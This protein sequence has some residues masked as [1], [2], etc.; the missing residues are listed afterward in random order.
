MPKKLLTLILAVLCLALFAAPFTAS[1][2]S[3]IVIRVNATFNPTTHGDMPL[4]KGFQAFKQKMEARF[5]GRVQVRITWEEALGKGHE[6]SMNGLQQSLFHL[7]FYPM[8]S[9]SEYTKA[10]IPFTNLFLVPYPHSQIVYD[11]FDGEIGKMVA[12]RMVQEA[13]IRPVAFLDIGF[14]HLLNNKGPVNALAD[15][16][17]MKYRVQPN[18]VHLAA[19]RA[20]GTNPTPIQISE[21][22]TALQQ[23]VVDGTE[24][25]LE[26]IMVFRLYEVQ[27]YLTLSGHAFEMGCLA[28]GEEF[29]QKLPADIRAG[30]TEVFREI[31]EEHR[32]YIAASD[33]QFLEFISSKMQ[34][35]Q[36]SAEQLAIF[37][38]IVEPGREASRQQA[39]AEYTNR[40][41]ELLAQYEKDYFARNPQ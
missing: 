24:N 15:L 26:N 21:L 8:T 22:F 25:P 1:A 6:A 17:G 18:P 12:E 27:K 5:P 32:G 40:F 16:K 20:L 4:V 36:L 3:P 2:Q 41:L 29:Y 13:R 38:D 11:A 31:T 28:M 39:G 10:A 14:R 19:F 33:K 23:G 34:V 7:Q 35:N 37:R 9:L 30:M